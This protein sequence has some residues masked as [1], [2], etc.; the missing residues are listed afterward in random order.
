MK[1]FFLLSSILMCCLFGYGQSLS[2]SA[3]TIE[4]GSVVTIQGVGESSSAYFANIGIVTGI[5]SSSPDAS[6]STWVSIQDAYEKQTYNTITQTPTSFKIKITNAHPDYNYTITFTILTNIQTSTGL[7]TNVAKTVTLTVKKPVVITT[8]YN[9]A[10]SQPFYKNDC[11]TGFESDPVNYS[12]PA[13]KYSSTI[14]KDDANAQAQAEINA[15]GQ[16]KA[17]TEGVCKQVYYNTEISAAF[18]RNNCTGNSLPGPEINYVV[19]ANKHK[20][21]ISQSDADL[22]AQ[23]DLNSNGQTYANINGVC[24]AQM[25]MTGITETNGG[26]A[27]N[28]SI[29]NAPLGSTFL[30]TVSSTI[31]NIQ[32]GSGSSN[33]AIYFK[34]SGATVDTY[35]E[36]KVEVT[37]N[38]GIKKIFTR[39]IKVKNCTTCP[40][41]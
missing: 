26:Q 1:K 28:F 39:T 3:T 27:H 21:L 31:G 2:P 7:Q 38:L 6:G 35:G 15:N 11:G 9:D 22:K 20:S 4:S 16:N 30:W 14:S 25:Y 40:E 12:V 36:V 33:V 32:S 24:I 5:T 17:N 19:Q 10:K 34:K 18:T 8:F 41:I 37:D 23:N 13:N 29:Q